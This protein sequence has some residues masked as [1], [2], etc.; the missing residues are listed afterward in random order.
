MIS[1]LGLV[2]SSSIIYA[3]TLFQRPDTVPNYAAYRNFDECLEAVNRIIREVRLKDTLWIDTA[4]Y[5]ASRN[6]RQVPENAVKYGRICLSGINLDSVPSKDYDLLIR[7]LLLSDMDSTAVRIVNNTLGKI[8]QPAKDSLFSVISSEY[9]NATPKRL[10][11]LKDLLSR[12]D[13]S[14]SRTASDGGDVLREIFLAR[15]AFDMGDTKYPLAVASEIMNKVGKYSSQL[16]KMPA[17][18]LEG[19]VYPF[20]LDVVELLTEEASDS[21]RISTTAYSK[22]PKEIWGRISSSPLPVG[23]KRTTGFIGSSVPQIHGDYW[24][25]NMKEEGNGSGNT[26]TYSVEKIAP[27]R[28]PAAGKVNVIVFLQGSCHSQGESVT[29][30][31]KGSMGGGGVRC[32]TTA[33]LVKR[34]KKKFPE[35]QVSIVS[36]TFGSIGSAPP[37]APQ[38]EADTL[39]D[40]FLNF[41]KIPGVHTV[42]KTDF[43]RMSGYDRRRLDLPVSYENDLMLDSRNIGE[44]GSVLLVDEDGRVFHASTQLSGRS[45]ALMMKKINTVL[46]RK[47]TAERAE[48]SRKDVHNYN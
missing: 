2:S 31:R 37:L 23:I 48:E 43:I 47:K 42:T 45:E 44:D 26:D 30:G 32:W 13:A 20:L 7:V 28:I 1:T 14:F 33:A 34:M 11:L 3:Q 22:F 40:Y 46:G 16:S 39:A 17:R 4:A 25:T 10:E 38:D 35:I 41:Y 9:S 5:D 19:S 18:D 24:Y 21:L 36:K 15:V 8:S 27:Q 12:D 29:R 6:I